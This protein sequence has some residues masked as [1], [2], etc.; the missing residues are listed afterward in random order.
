MAIQGSILTNTQANTALKVLNNTK[1]QLADVQNKISTGKAVASAKDGPATFTIAETMRGDMGAYK[2]IKENIGVAQSTVSVAASATEKISDKL[3]ELEEQ[4]ASTDPDAKS[5]GEV[6]KSIDETVGYIKKTITSAQFNGVNYLTQDQGQNVTVGLDR[7]GGNLEKTTMTF[8]AHNMKVSGGDLSQLDNIDVTSTGS[9]ISRSDLESASLS[10]DGQTEVTTAAPAPADVDDGDT[11][12]VTYDNGSQEVTKTL[13]FNTS[14][15]G[16]LKDGNHVEIDLDKAGSSQTEMAKH[17]AYAL[18]GGNTTS[19]SSTGDTE[20]VASADAM[21][22]YSS[23]TSATNDVGIKQ[24]GSGNLTVVAKT[25]GTKGEVGIKDVGGTLANKD[26]DLNNALTKIKNARDTVDTALSDFGSVQKRLEDQ[27]SFVGT[28]V[29]TMDK[30]VGHL[31]DANMAEQAAKLQALQA[32]QQLGNR[33]LSIANRQPQS[34][35]SVFGG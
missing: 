31:V 3:A 24:D 10:T 14:G 8:Q 13:E 28:M 35:L 21:S 9:A 19:P 5:N 17:I 1:S 11:L 2:Q 27:K 22:T 32:Q 7:S 30:G 20:T 33:S 25:D 6:Q 12:T 34:L 23:A 18:S 4:V 15:S 16:G 29:D 26:Y